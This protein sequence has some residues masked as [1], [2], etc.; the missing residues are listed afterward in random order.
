VVHIVRERPVVT[1]EAALERL[2]R[3]LGVARDW[4]DLRL[5]LPQAEAGADPRLVRS[6]LASS[7]AAALE[8]AKQGRAELAQDAMF[9]PLRLRAVS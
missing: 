8:L 2:S 4:V 6:A 9:G 3:L 1:L 7:F 5:L